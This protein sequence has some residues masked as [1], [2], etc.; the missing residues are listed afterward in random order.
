MTPARLHAWLTAALDR[1]SAS[2]LFCRA[3][4]ALFARSPAFRR[5]VTRRMGP[6]AVLRLT[7]FVHHHPARTIAT[8]SFASKLG[9]PGLV[10]RTS[11]RLLRDGWDPELAAEYLAAMRALTPV[12]EFGRRA[13]AIER[14]AIEHPPHPGL[15]VELALA[16]HA[17]ERR[18]EALALAEQAQQMKPASSEARRL[19]EWL[20]P[21]RF[22][23][24]QPH[25]PAAPGGIEL[26]IGL[27]VRAAPD[28]T[29]AAAPAPLV[30]VLELECGPLSHPTAQALAVRLLEVNPL[31]PHDACAVANLEPFCLIVHSSALR[32]PLRL[33]AALRL[34][35][36]AIAVSL[37]VHV[38]RLEETS[39]ESLRT[40][41][42]FGPIGCA[43]WST[44]Y[45]LL[46]MGV[47]AYYSGALAPR[48]EADDRIRAV[49][50]LCVGGLRS[51][52]VREIPDRLRRLCEPYVREARA[53][54]GVQPAPPRS[55]DAL[56]RLVGPLADEPELGVID[57]ALAFDAG[58]VTRVPAVLQ[59]LAAS[60]RTPLRV[61]CCLRGIR[62]R[63]SAALAGR[64]PE[65]RF[66]FISMDEVDYGGT[67]HFYGQL[68][69]STMDRLLLPLLLPRLRRLVY[70]DTDLVILEA[71]DGL[72]TSDP[73]VLGIAARPL[74]HP[75]WSPLQRLTEQIARRNPLADRVDEIRR[76]MS[77]R[78]D[79]G[80][81]AF[82]TGVLLMDL[83]RLRD[84]RFSD[85]TLDLSV[86]YGLMDNEATAL[87]ANGR[88][89]PLAARWNYIPGIEYQEHPAVIHWA[90]ALKPWRRGEYVPHREIWQSFARAAARRR[91]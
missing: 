23:P 39:G 84:A 68:T 14:A 24:A 31:C 17:A 10:A 79:L 8:A 1:H 82:N 11:E 35:A 45:L 47:E 83:E 7:R 91:V 66:R 77:A 38:D 30:S 15:L 12:T 33:N 9:L 75:S 50:G 54:A 72:W 13:A 42:A 37:A 51:G 2:R 67:F 41:A 56:A 20:T 18:S 22:G 74:E 59:S 88:F 25:P 27:L 43:D 28:G 32:H 3:A 78:V 40:L 65:I 4:S 6:H 60:T 73:G 61:F 63:Q 49:V 34:P 62:P 58:L 44:V 21:C 76:E 70:L 80:A 29:R 89:A 52:A 36:H 48:S 57:V 46:N 71:V 85:E 90:G 53:R 69:M 86:R 81:S 19:I 16:H 26:E 64:F 5:Y 55:V 87:W